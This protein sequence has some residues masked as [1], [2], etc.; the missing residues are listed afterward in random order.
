M[1]KRFFQV[2]WRF[3]I[4]IACLLAVFVLNAVYATYIILNPSATPAS[5]KILLLLLRSKISHMLVAFCLMI[6]SLL[7]VIQILLYTV[8]LTDEKIYT[9]GQILWRK[10]QYPVNIKY[11]EIYKLGLLCTYS[12]SL[13][14]KINAGCGSGMP[15]LFLQ[16]YT[17]SKKRPTNI[18]IELFS[19]KQ[20]KQIVELI[21][22]YANLGVTYEQL[23]PNKK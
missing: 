11:S 10:V 1:K 12:N 5:S 16:V 7:N 20:R 8:V 6:L 23:L 22:N 14:K 19:I 4:I 3:W 15:H 21:S 17:T 2:G 9:H 18:L 13:G